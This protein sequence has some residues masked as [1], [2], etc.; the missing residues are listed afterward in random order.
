[1]GSI[2][3]RKSNKTDHVFAKCLKLHSSD[4]NGGQVAIGG[5]WLVQS[6]EAMPVIIVLYSSAGL[7][8]AHRV[9]I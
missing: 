1:M 2:E 6:R 5:G 3:R 4:N 8:H 7:C 9:F